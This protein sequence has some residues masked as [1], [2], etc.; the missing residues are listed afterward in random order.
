VARLGTR[1]GHTVVL[2]GIEQGEYDFVVVN[3]KNVQDVLADVD[4]VA[5]CPMDQH[6][7]LFPP[8]AWLSSI[9]ENS[10]IVS[11]GQ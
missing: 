5:G 2:L 9:I 10:P 6:H 8:R 4:G 11:P 1:L 7:R 3:R